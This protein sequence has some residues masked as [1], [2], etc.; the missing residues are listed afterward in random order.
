MIITCQWIFKLKVLQKAETEN[1]QYITILPS[2]M[3]VVNLLICNSLNLQKLIVPVLS[4]APASGCG[5]LPSM[6]DAFTH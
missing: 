1:H 4:P 2:D 5:V 6:F 3:K